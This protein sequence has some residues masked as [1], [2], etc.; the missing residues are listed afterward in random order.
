MALHGQD[1]RVISVRILGTRLRTRP[2]DC[3]F[4]GK[5]RIFYPFSPI[6]HTERIEYADESFFSE[7]A[8]FPVW[9]GEDDAEKSVI[10]SHFRVFK[11]GR[12]AKTYQKVCVIGMDR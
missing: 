5:R 2:H 6:V 9:I 7:N 11:S 10:Y 1:V 8:P 3:V 4:V 12:W